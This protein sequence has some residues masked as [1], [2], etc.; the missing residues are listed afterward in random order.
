MPFSPRLVRARDRAHA[1]VGCAE[2][3]HLDAAQLRV[4]LARLVP[5]LERELVRALAQ[6]RVKLDVVV[7]AVAPD[8]LAWRPAEV[9]AVEAHDEVI[10]AWQ[11][12]ER[13]AERVPRVRAARGERRGPR[14]GGVEERPRVRLERHRAPL[15]ARLLVGVREPV[16]PGDGRGGGR[17]VDA[18]VAG[19]HAAV[20]L[21]ADVDDRVAQLVPEHEGAVRERRR[22]DSV[23]GSQRCRLRESVC[24]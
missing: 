13:E 18:E 11:A 10:R 12:G 16:R 22:N 17:G 2:L 3:E 24:C 21:L 7:P 14:G 19:V 6:R 9:R 20:V 5:Q 1:L 8:V 4:A 15:D 23:D